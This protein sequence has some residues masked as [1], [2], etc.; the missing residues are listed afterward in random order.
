MVAV[1]LDGNIILA[2]RSEQS[3]QYHFVLAR[4]LGGPSDVTTPAAVTTQLNQLVTTA[5]QSGQ[6]V[7]VTFQATTTDQYQSFVTAFSSGCTCTE[8][9]SQASRNLMS[10]GKRACFFAAGPSNSRA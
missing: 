3:L 8:S 1:Q 10:Q 2:G 4:L 9:Q 5:N 7:Q 6:P